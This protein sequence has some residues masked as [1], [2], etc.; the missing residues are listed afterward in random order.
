MFYKCE[1][2]FLA[3]S[4]NLYFCTNSGT[5]FLSLFVAVPEHWLEKVV[6]NPLQM[7][8]CITLCSCPPA[9]PS[10]D[11][12]VHYPLKLPSCICLLRCPHALPSAAVLVHYPLK[13]SSCITLFSC[14]RATLSAAVITPSSCPHVL[15]FA[16]VLGHY[17]L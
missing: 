15:P 9:L 17:L 1:H 12:F 6:S 14:P 3:L 16:A 5:P 7:S 13:V 11:V 10:S 2:F 8:S 4:N